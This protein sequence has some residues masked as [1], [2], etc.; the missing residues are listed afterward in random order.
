M[1]R[2]L[3]RAVLLPVLWYVGGTLLVPLLNGAGGRAE[4]WSHAAVVLL[5]AGTVALLACAVRG[6]TIR[7]AKSGKLRPH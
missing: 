6:V 2:R 5:V 4:F 7:F 1:S 3:P